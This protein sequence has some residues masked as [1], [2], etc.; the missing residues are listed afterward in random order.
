MENR[1]GFKDLILCVLLIAIVI[2]IWLGMVQTGRQHD[3]LLRM[4]EQIEQ[5]TTAQARLEQTVKQVQSQLAAGV[6]VQSNVGT[7]TPPA[8]TLTDQGRKAFPRLV[9]ATEI[10]GFAR[11]DWMIDAFAQAPGSVTP[12]VSKDIYGRRIQSYVLEALIGRDPVTLEDTPVVAESWEVEDNTEAWQTWLDGRLAEG[13][14]RDAA[15]REEGAPSA[16]TITFKLRPG[17]VFS[18]GHPLTT[19]DVAFSWELLNNSA[20]DAP[21]E[22][23]FYDNVRTWEIIDDLTIR[24]ETREPHF[25]ALSMAGSRPIMP[26]H[27]YERFTP[28]ELNKSTGLLMGSGPYRMPTAEG[29]RPGDPIELVRNERFWGPTPA[30]NRL[31]WKVINDDVARMTQFRNGEIDLFAAVPEQYK[32]LLEDPAIVERSSNFDYDTVPA[33]YSFIAWNQRREGEATIFAD[34]RVRQAMTYLTNR[35]GICEDIKLGYATPANGP[36]PPGSLQRNPG[37]ETRNFNLAKG[38]ALLAEAGWED[39][40]GDGVIENEAG[41]PFSFTFTYSQGRK[42]TDRIAL[43]LKDNYARAGIQM[44]PEKLEWAVFVERLDNR[45]FDAVTLGWGGGAV[46][47][48]VRQM[49][50]SSQIANAANNFTSYSNTEL[51]TLIDEARIT[52]DTNERM[53]L[54]H[55]VHTILWEDQPYTFMYTSKALRFIDDRIRNIEQITAGL[56]DRDEWFVPA[57]MQKWK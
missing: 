23:A 10:P 16:L 18:D 2:S 7:A 8:T 29:W 36:Y 21:A 41:E 45:N 56:N 39:R 3:L 13:I 25:L 50:H 52:L 30:F 1:F 46:E 20:I 55:Q 49:F 57:G 12:L 33:G 15:L 32:E 9:Q 42:E 17:V 11:G 19:E 31:V 27:F 43:Y 54:W 35:Q 37:L 51:D 47:S 22:R 48:D 53:K 44:T 14:E 26:K 38:K 24:F 5:Q 40:D 4:Q 28:D 6:A 34:K